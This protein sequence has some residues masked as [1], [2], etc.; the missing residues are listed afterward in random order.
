MVVA[1]GDG[2]VKLFDLNVNDFPVKTWKEH[3]REVYAV[4][5]NL[6]SKD[7]FASSSWDGTIKIV[8]GTFSLNNPLP[9]IFTPSFKHLNITKLIRLY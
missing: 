8:R 1:S 2:S 3:N 7:T 4:H 9:P 6:V 5:W